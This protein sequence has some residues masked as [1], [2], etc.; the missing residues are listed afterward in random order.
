MINNI[1]RESIDGHLFSGIKIS[2]WERI[3]QKTIFS[4]NANLSPSE[5]ESK[6]PKV[7]H[8]AEIIL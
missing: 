5:Q 6:K 2:N 4:C 1:T 3:F 8:L 7:H